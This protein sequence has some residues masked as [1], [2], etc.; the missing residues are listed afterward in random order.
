VASEI[1]NRFGSVD[2]YVEPFAGS[3]AVLLARPNFDPQHPPCETS[4]DLDGMIVNFWRAVRADPDELARQCD[5]PVT[6]V[7]LTSRHKFLVKKGE[8]QAF[9]RSLRDDPK[10]YDLE[11]AAYWVYGKSCWIGS[12]F[13]DGEWDP[14]SE[15]D[16]TKRRPALGSKCKI[17]IHKK[18]ARGQIGSKIPI[19]GSGGRGVHKTSIPSDIKMPCMQ[20]GGSGIHAFTPAS[21]KVAGAPPC[22]EWFRTLQVRLRRVRLPCGDWRRVLTPAVTTGNGLTGV[23]FDPP[24]SSESDRTCNVY[25]NEDMEVAH[26]VRGW[27]LE[28]GEDR[29]FRLA[30]CGY[31]GEHDEL[32]EH[33][34]S[35]FAWKAH[36]GYGLQAKGK[37]RENRMRERVWFSPCCQRGVDLF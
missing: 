4:N 32:L 5:W 34:W 20:R 10:Y 29:M 26:A 6:E 1:W 21:R 23:F 16:F 12:G 8:K 14:E 27:C 18:S 15:E 28:H 2:N 25:S 24:Y 13:C 37:G 3:M 17:G 35:V 19:M 30:L 9:L 11:R 36:G 31:E 22:L 33:G 7:D